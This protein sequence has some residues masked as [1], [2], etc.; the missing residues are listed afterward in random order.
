MEAGKHWMPV[1]QHPNEPPFRDMRRKF[2]LGQ[3][4]DTHSIGC[5]CNNVGR[6]ID[7]HRPFDTHLQF[8]SPPLEFPCVGAAGA[9][10]LIDATMLEQIARCP[11]SSA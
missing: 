3:K 10:S 2:F 5:F 4:R 9:L 6:G 11:S 8:T 1:L 7:R